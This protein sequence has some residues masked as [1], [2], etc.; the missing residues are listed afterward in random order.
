MI[1]EVD[2]IGISDVRRNVPS[3]LLVS[4]YEVRSD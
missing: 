4:N 2:R 1:Q 3:R